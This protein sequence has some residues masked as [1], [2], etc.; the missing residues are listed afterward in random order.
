MQV[1]IL[2]EHFRSSLAVM[3]GEDKDDQSL[4]ARKAEKA[5]P[6]RRELGQQIE[7]KLRESEKWKNNLAMRV[8]L[9]CEDY[10]NWRDQFETVESAVEWYDYYMH[11]PGAEGSPRIAGMRA[12]HV[13]L[14]K[15]EPDLAEAKSNR[16]QLE[17]LRQTQK[18]IEHQKDVFQCHVETQC[19]TIAE[20]LKLP[21]SING[22]MM[23]GKKQIAQKVGQD[24]A[25]IEQLL[26]K[27]IT[28]AM[29]E[30][31][32][33]LRVMLA[34]STE[35]VFQET[36]NWL[37]MYVCMYVWGSRNRKNFKYMYYFKY[38]CT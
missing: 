19:S 34:T 6:M 14:D 1:K 35:V 4:G 8:H 23:E 29:T 28:I 10:M 21:I 18:E 20:L 3:S 27:A 30:V 12:L 33:R 11:N 24:R 32:N 2:A 22:K 15:L 37:C 9:F 38:I 25:D 7:R 17:V 36:K 16:V 13:A 31:A 5:K 26:T